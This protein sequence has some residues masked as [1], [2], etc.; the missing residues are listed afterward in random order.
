MKN[1]W[2]KL[3]G[4]AVLALAM[5]IPAGIRAAAAQIVPGPIDTSQWSSLTNGTMTSVSNAPF[6]LQ[7]KSD[8]AG[9]IDM[10]VPGGTNATT[11]YFNLGIT[12][13]W[14]TTYPLSVLVT[15]LVVG[16]A[17]NTS[18]FYLARTNFTGFDSLRCDKVVSAGT[19]GATAVT[20]TLLGSQPP[21]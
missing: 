4:I 12:N 8:L 6:R 19:N 10:A 18:P 2:Q 1:K 5:V 16:G 17:T 11:F 7:Q 13:H 9:M 3:S 21:D 20:G 14:T 15:N